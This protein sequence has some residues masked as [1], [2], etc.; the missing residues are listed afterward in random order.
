MNL[1]HSTLLVLFAVTI[2]AFADKPK[3]AS[4]TGYLTTAANGV[5]IPSPISKKTHPVMD[6]KRSVEVPEAM[7]YIPAGKSEIGE[8]AAVTTVDLSGYC[9]GKFPV[10]NA[11]Y[12]AFL[13]DN[14]SIDGPSYWKKGT[15]PEGKANHPVVYVSLTDAAAYARWVSVKTG[16]KFAIPTSN[17]W[18]KAAR[19]PKGFL[20]PWGNSMDAEYKGGVLTTKFNFNAVTA[21]YYLKNRPTLEVTYDNPKSKYHGTKTTVEKIAGFDASGSSKQL[22]VSASGNVQGWVSHDTYTGFIYTDLF[23]SLND[24]GGNTS[25]VGNYEEGK[26][27]YGCYDMAG[28]GWNWCDTTIQATNGAEKGKSVNE[29]RGGSWYATGRSCRSVSI[30]EGRRGSG[31]YNTVGFRIVMNP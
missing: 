28:N 26:S 24:K 1:L 16:W 10:T 9:F 8:G 19:G 5:G 3:L 21:A 25:P 15:F 27:S 6:G 11:E 29:I 18:E 30:G 4:S 14:K 2:P 23:S 20:Y 22:S 12:K 31:A 7:V 13:D 17:Q